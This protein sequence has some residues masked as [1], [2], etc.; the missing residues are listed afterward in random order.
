MSAEREEYE[1][2]HPAGQSQLYEEQEDDELMDE[3]EDD[4]D[5]NQGNQ[6]SWTSKS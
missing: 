4:Y 1:E 2:E 5:V 3:L 6:P